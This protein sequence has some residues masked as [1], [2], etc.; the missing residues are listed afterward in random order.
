MNKRIHKMIK[1]YFNKLNNLFKFKN[2]LQ[3][4]LNFC[5]FKTKK[6]KRKK[7]ISKIHLLNF[8]CSIIIK[9]LLLKRRRHIIQLKKNSFIITRFKVTIHMTQ[10][11]LITY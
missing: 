8:L 9:D 2:N 11:E 4:S 6:I 5:K 1:I 10:N 3:I 7:R